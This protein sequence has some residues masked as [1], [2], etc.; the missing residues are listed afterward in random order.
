MLSSLCVCVCVCVCV[1][2]ERAT[3]TK[4]DSDC[5]YNLARQ[6]PLT[7]RHDLQLNR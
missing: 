1:C 6:F 2:E 3:E 7:S 4:L 5:T